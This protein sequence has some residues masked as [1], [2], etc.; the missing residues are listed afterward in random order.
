MN[1]FQ[2]KTYLWLFFFYGLSFFVLGISALQ[3]KFR[4]KSEFP[5]LTTIQLIGA[6]GVLHGIAEW[7]AMLRMMK[8]Y[9]RFEWQLYTLETFLTG[10]SFL[11]L[12][13]FGFSM[14]LKETTKNIKVHIWIP[15]LIFSLWLFFF[16]GRIS[17]VQKDLMWQ[18]TIFNNLTRYFMGLPGAILAGISF[19]QNSNHLKGLRL[20]NYAKMYMTAGIFF[21]LYGLTSGVFIAP[22]DIFP[23]N[24][25]NHVIFYQYTGIPV[26]LVRAV[27]A[28][29]ITVI[30]IRIFDSF[31][32][33]IQRRFNEY[34]QHQLLIQDRKKTIQ[35]VHDQ[36]IQRLFGAGMLVESLLDVS[37]SDE[38]REG[39]EEL[40]SDLNETIKEAR[41]FLK[42][43]SSSYI[44]IE[45]L[46]ENLL[47][48]TEQFQRTSNVNCDYNYLVPTMVMGKISTDIN[49]ELYYIIQESLMNIQKHSKAK[50][51]RI[52]VYS[53]L[54]ELV[55]ELDDDGVGFNS[56]KKNTEG[57][58]IQNMKDRIIR[59]N[60]S[61]EI[62]SSKE[63]T[64]IMVKVPWEDE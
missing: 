31:S 18:I 61:M 41:D 44:G 15:L 35:M 20:S 14:V 25:L 10:F 46:K 29:G 7:I 43:F 28:I 38:M 24:V 8:A 2:E 9:D 4:H 59:I 51:V 1:Q 19:F 36:I 16:L 52:S 48:L 53:N 58:G 56:N 33:E 37:E 21:F 34:E 6:F 30:T 62:K 47:S 64:R 13:I 49:A 54:K 50:N 45:D 32:W 17:S 60:G 40:K 39:L 23:S 11:F 42:T 12:M 26:E 27:S 5:L 3:Q 22:L 55:V 57:Y 63:G